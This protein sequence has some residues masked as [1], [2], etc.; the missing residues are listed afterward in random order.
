MSKKKDCNSPV[1]ENMI[2]QS[3]VD[4][5]VHIVLDEKPN[6]SLDDRTS[7]FSSSLDYYDSDDNDQ[8]PT[9]A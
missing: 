5:G 7:D 2:I 9:F 6:D 1:S 3:V 4:S 8:D